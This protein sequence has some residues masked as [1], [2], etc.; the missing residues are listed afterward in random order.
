VIAVADWHPN[1]GG[2]ASDAYYRAFRA[3]FPAASDD[4]LVLRMPMMIDML[5]AAM[6]RA[7]S[8]DP[9]AVARA[10]EGMRFEGGGFHPSTMRAA[11]HQLIQPLYVME[12]DKAGAPGVKFDNEGS[13]YGFRTLLAVPAQATA[14]A[15]TCK[16]AR[17][18]R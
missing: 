16:M 13:G 17:P 10:L 9:L 1:A 11:D 8:A 3:R 15:T 6:T 18:S 5:A 7:G 12:M 2:A 4:Y 14:Q